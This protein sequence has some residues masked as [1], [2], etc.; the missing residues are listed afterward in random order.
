MGE[1]Y[2]LL[3]AAKQQIPRSDTAALGDDNSLRIFNLLR[4]H[5]SVSG[6]RP[7]EIVYN[8]VASPP[9]SLPQKLPTTISSR[10]VSHKEM[11]EVSARRSP[12]RILVVDDNQGLK[13][14]RQELLATRG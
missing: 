12:P 3:P 6:S 13:G 11:N 1:G 7:L 5:H 4:Y 8:K 10:S 2:A 14:L 9:M